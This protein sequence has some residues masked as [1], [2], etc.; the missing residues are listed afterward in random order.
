MK[1]DSRACQGDTK[2]P[3]EGEEMGRGAVGEV[4]EG[5]KADS[6]PGNTVCVSMGEVCPGE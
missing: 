4:G 6:P 5:I 1:H 3:G 2:G